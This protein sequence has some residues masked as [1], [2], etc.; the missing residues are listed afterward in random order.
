[1]HDD[2]G[3]QF[4]EPKFPS[5]LHVMKLGPSMK[6]NASRPFP[7]LVSVSWSGTKWE[8]QEHAGAGP[9]H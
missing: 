1:M 6:P 5:R 2:G 4:G 9:C 7:L 8:R 3:S